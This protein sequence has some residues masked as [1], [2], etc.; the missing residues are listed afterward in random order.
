MKKV[1]VFIVFLF[2]NFGALGLGSYL[3]GGSP[4]SNSWYQDLP[5]APWTPAGW[6]FGA[7]WFTIMLLFSVYMSNIWLNFKDNNRTFLIYF[8]QLA[9]NIFWNPVFFYFH[10]VLL[11]FIILLLLFASLVLLLTQSRTIKKPE[12]L[13]VLPY[14]IWLVI[15]ISLNLYPLIV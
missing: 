8:M 4:A 11:A 14:L 9:L 3:M 12:G 1:L 13:L 7:A 5:K 10:E 2:L 6:V 15:A